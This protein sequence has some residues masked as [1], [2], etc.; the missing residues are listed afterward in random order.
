[1]HAYLDAWDAEFEVATE[2]RPILEN[3]I[4]GWARL[5]DLLSDDK[6]PSSAQSAAEFLESQFAQQAL[7]SYFGDRLAL[8]HMDYLTTVRPRRA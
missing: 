2:D 6:A 4:E 3:W 8:P 5:R 7:T 1:M